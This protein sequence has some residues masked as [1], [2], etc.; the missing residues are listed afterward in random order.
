MHIRH[1]Q[2]KDLPRILEIYEKARHFMRENG[3]PRQWGLLNWPPEDMIRQDIDTGKGYVCVENE[4]I[5]AVFFFEHGYRIDPTYALIEDGSWLG[6]DNYGVV[7][8]IASASRQKGVAAFCIQWAYNQCGHLRIDTHG[9]NVPMQNLLKKLG[10]SY[11]G[12]IYVGVDSDP[13]LAYEK[14]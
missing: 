13:R 5:L 6:D 1:S 8:R 11:R 14:V 4:E 9:D 3:N 10:F 12:I 7:H 2:L